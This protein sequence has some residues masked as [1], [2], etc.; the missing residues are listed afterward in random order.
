MTAYWQKCKITHNPL[1]G[2]YQVS[3]SDGYLIGEFLTL[4]EAIEAIEKA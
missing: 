3:Y 2:L 1:Y 4:S